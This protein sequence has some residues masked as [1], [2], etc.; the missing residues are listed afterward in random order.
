MRF[1][2]ATF[3][4]TTIVCGSCGSKDKKNSTSKDIFTADTTHTPYKYAQLHYTE[5]GFALTGKYAAAIPVGILGNTT[6][7]IFTSK[8][9]GVTESI[10]DDFEGEAVT[11]TQLD[12]KLPD[13]APFSDML[14]V[15]NYTDQSYSLVATDTITDTKVID[16]LK[17]LVINSG[18][19]KTLYTETRETHKFDA[20]AKKLF[21]RAKE[22]TPKVVKLHIPGL[23][24]FLLSYVLDEKYNPE[25]DSSPVLIVINGKAYT[26]SGPCGGVTSVYK[27]GDNYFFNSEWTYCFQDVSWRIV[28]E[29]RA[30]GLKQEVMF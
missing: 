4:F 15:L 24:A 13:D 20:Y 7:K 18:A 12:K 9:T 6:G 29:I 21:E 25:N 26:A 11:V 10:E 3:L 16:S 2:Q 27:L 19:L 5:K 30:D 22:K 23:S 1:L 8:T 17:R 14:A 28:F